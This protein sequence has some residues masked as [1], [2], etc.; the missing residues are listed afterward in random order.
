MS[1][2]LASTQALLSAVTKS[3]KPLTVLLGSPASAPDSP[4]ALGVSSV[5]EI[6]GM[7]EESVKKED[8]F[9]QFN[10][11]VTSINSNDRYQDGFDF[12]KNYLSQDAVN[13][14]IKKA[15]LKAYDDKTDSWY[16]PKGLD[17]LCSL[18]SSH[19]VL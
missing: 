18:I 7:I 17:A 8:L 9:D 6:V 13:D 16:I 14:I 1:N 4:N 15:V 3:K 2:H 10:D 19:L 12:I 11:V 5:T